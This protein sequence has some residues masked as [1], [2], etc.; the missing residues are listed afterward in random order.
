M[1]PI[2]AL[3]ADNDA[4]GGLCADRPAARAQGGLRGRSVVTGWGAML[5]RHRVGSGRS[6]TSARVNPGPT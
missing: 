1:K 2:V 4:N 5:E 3:P 6:N